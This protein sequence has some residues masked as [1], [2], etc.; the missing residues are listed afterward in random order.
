M[1][2]LTTDTDRL[3]QIIRKWK[4]VALDY[5]YKGNRPEYEHIVKTVETVT[6]EIIAGIKPEFDREYITLVLSE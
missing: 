6:T 1:K 4:K 3:A 5:L 2:A